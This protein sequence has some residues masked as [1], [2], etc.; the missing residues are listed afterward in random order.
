MNREIVI[1]S[2]NFFHCSQATYRDARTHLKKKKRRRSA[3]ETVSS[4]L[5]E[6]RTGGLMGRLPP[7]GQIG[8]ASCIDFCSS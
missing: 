2:P 7:L 4:M 3:E 5:F 1:Q 6:K 8:G